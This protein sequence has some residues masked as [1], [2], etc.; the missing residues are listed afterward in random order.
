MKKENEKEDGREEKKKDKKKLHRIFNF[1]N[2]EDNRKYNKQLQEKYLYRLLSCEKSTEDKVISLCYHATKTQLQPDINK[3]AELYNTLYKKRN[4]LRTMEGFIKTFDENA[5]ISYE[6]LFN[7]I[8][9]KG[10]FGQSANKTSAIFVK[11]IYQLHNLNYCK[12]KF[13]LWNDVPKKIINDK[14]YLPVDTVIETIF[15]RIFPNRKLGFKS[16]NDILSE[17]Y[18]PEEIEVWDDLWFWGFITQKVENVENKERVFK[19]NKEKYWNLWEANKEEIKAI[20]NLSTKF[21]KIIN[22][23]K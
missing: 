9:R 12:G 10:C 17:H 21:I 18:K 6:S 13:K 23:S 11:I 14:I 1:L 8:R 22:D 5:N 2:K 15:K 20:K 16:I 3:L 4:E 7:V 19:F